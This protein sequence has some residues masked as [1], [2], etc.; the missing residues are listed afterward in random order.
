MFFYFSKFVCYWWEGQSDT[1]YLFFAD[2]TSDNYYL[3]N[4]W[5]LSSLTKLFKHIFF[6]TY[7]LNTSYAA[8]NKHLEKSHCMCF[9]IFFL[10][11]IFLYNIKSAIR[12]KL[13]CVIG[14]HLE[15]TEMWVQEKINRKKECSSAVLKIK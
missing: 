3:N 11:C 7:V 4:E 10:F 1:S 2:S 15:R 5:T 14:T 12:A 9:I 8:M 13:H 6:N